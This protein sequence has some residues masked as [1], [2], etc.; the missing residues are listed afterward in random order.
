MKFTIRDLIATT[1]VVALLIVHYQERAATRER[2]LFIERLARDRLDVLEGWAAYI[3]RQLD[4]DHKW[5]VSMEGQFSELRTAIW[6]LQDSPTTKHT[7][8]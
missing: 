3:D 8:P 1:I 7:G 5:D 4:D 2:E 6:K